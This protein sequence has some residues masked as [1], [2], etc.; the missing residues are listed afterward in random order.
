MGQLSR[1]VPTLHQE[2]K[3]HLSTLLISPQFDPGFACKPLAERPTSKKRYGRV[4]QGL[5]PGDIFRFTRLRWEVSSKEIGSGLKW[6]PMMKG[7]EFRRYFSNENWLFLWQKSGVE[8]K[9]F[10]EQRYG[11]ASRTIKNESEFFKPGITFPRVSSVGMNGRLMPQDSVFSDTGMA[12]IPEEEA[13]TWNLLALF[14]SRLADIICAALH[15]GRKFEVAHLAAIPI[16]ERVL[17]DEGLR[18][19]AREA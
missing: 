4:R 15:P 6:V 3:L 16:E 18:T 9:A 19:L 11:G 2:D 10:A 7:G 12:I 1:P 13:S 5:I 8:P 17:T 14:N